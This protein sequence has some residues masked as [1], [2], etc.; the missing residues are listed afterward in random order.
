MA[1]VYTHSDA[2]LELELATPH[3][4]W[5][6]RL[7][8]GMWPKPFVFWAVV[9]YIGL[10]II[11]PWEKLIPE[12]GPMR[13][14]RLSV[15]AIMAI[16]VLRRGPLVRFTFQNIA[17][18]GLFLAVFISGKRGFDPSTSGQEV[19]EFFGFLL[20]FFLIQKAVRS[21]YQALFLIASYLM[22]TT[23][24]VGKSIWEYAFNGA[25]QVMMGVHRLAG[26]DSTYGHPNTIGRTMLCSLP[27]A[28]CFYRI[29]DQF[30]QTWPSRMQKLFLWT[31]RAHMAFCVIGI[32]LTRSR[33]AAIGLVFFAMLLVSRQRGAAKKLRWGFAAAV[34]FVVGFSLAP[35]DIQYRIRSIWDS[36]V[37]AEADMRG[38][39]QSKAGRYEGFLA[40]L[41]I[42]ERFPAT[43]VGIGNFAVYR[44]TYVD[45]V[46][47]NAHNLPGELLGELGT[48]GTVAFS[49]FFLAYYLNLRKL[50][51]V[52]SEYDRLTG[53]PRYRLLSVCLFDSMLLLLIYGLAGHTLQQY[54]WYFYA[55]FVA[56]ALH[57]AK[58][59]LQTVRAEPDMMEAVPEG[60]PV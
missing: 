20:I 56:I 43:G 32:L 10:F 11:R 12:L 33:S 40:G 13:F 45:G 23:A 5:V 35:T 18:I 4:A 27:F 28:I 59:E 49:V 22:L 44:E 50:K 57:F 38:A 30:C 60:V 25:A 37:E 16:V 1:S 39:N 9:F 24:Y 7:R 58:Q 17:M 29:R 34:I 3:I 51:H 52:G 26:I 31:L 15:M 55:S 48:V 42:F 8:H 14:E 21:P 41:A 47:L 2:P 54:Q 19:T 46:K 53:N 36:R 6:D